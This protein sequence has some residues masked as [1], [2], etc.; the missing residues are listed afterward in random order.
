MMFFLRLFA[1]C[2]L[3]LLHTMGIIFGWLTYCFSPTYRKR[4]KQNL[5]E[6]AQYD[7]SVLYQ[8]IGEAGKA[9]IELLPVWVRK[10]ADVLKLIKKVHNFACIEQV[11]AQQKSIV[12]LT[13]HLGCFEIASLYY[14]Q[15]AKLSILYRPPKLKWLIPIMEQGRKRGQVTLAPADL[16]GVRILLRALKNQEDIGILPD[17][18]PA[19]GEG[20]TVHFF[21]KP[22]YTM[23]LAARLARQPNIAVIF[24]FAK[25]LSWGRGFEVYF[26]SVNFPTD[27]ADLT[28][29]TQ[30]LNQQIETLIRLAPAQY[31]WSYNRYKMPKK[32][33]VAIH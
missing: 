8:T 31:L 13:P 21:N 28:Q 22:A 23:T 17:Q 1:Y 7:T 15:K 11:K 32:H 20:V 25:R 27:Q 19:Q 10:E 5:C 26:Q 4:L 16:K 30:F 14:A 9:S 29:D 2:P 6:I 33:D 3:W 12:F 24:A 18:V